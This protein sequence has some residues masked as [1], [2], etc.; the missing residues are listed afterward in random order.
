VHKQAIFISI[1]TYLN[2]LILKAAA[3]NLVHL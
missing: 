3:I 2:Q 1:P